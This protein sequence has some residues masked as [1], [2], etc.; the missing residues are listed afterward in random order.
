M[1]F[2]DASGERRARVQLLSEQL[3][4][5][6]ADFTGAEGL[7]GCRMGTCEYQRDG[8]Q[9]PARKTE[10][11]DHRDPV[12]VRASELRDAVE[13]LIDSLAGRVLAKEDRTGWDLV[14][15]AQVRKFGVGIARHA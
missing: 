10:A 5:N 4:G 8:A 1:H 15:R 11:D 3:G 2:V 7:D 13:D 12:V 14:T 9:Q 6:P